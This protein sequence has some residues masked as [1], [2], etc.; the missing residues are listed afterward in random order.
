MKIRVLGSFGGEGQGQ[1]PSSFLVNDHV[2]VDA[3]AVAGALSAPEQ[4]KID[5]ALLSHAHLDHIVGLAFLTDTLAITEAKTPVI[6]TGIAPVIDALRTHG[7]NNSLWPDFSAIPSAE[8]PVLRFRTLPEDTESRVGELWVRP[9][10][11]DH[12]VPTTGFI[13]HDGDTGFVYSGD[14]GPTERIW[15]AARG[16]RGL[17][18]VVVETAFPNRLDAMATASKHLTPAKLLREMDKIPP[19]LPL[20]IYHIKPQFLEE[21]VEE[22]MKVG[23]SRIHILEQGKTYTL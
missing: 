12:T 13:I 21:T 7:F 11:V 1:R 15:A 4:G 9:V 5:Y 16:L 17:R 14:T 22:L 3:G 8:A 20:W 19:D 10:P 2:L 6:A 18:A 23:S